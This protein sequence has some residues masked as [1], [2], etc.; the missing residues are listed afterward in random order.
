MIGN[1]I[2]KGVVDQTLFEFALVLRDARRK[3]ETIRIFLENYPVDA[4][5]ND[6]L[7]GSYPGGFEYTPEEAVIIRETIGQFESL[8]LDEVVLATRKFTGLL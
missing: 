1:D 4:E 2:S 8:P 7:T 5:G 3:S 6:P